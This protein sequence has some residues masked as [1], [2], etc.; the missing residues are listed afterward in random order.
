MEEVKGYFKY[1]LYAMLLYTFEL[2][3]NT[4]GNYNKMG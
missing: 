1:Y 3:V 4:Q 2:I